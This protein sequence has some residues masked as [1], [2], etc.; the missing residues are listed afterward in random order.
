MQRA[1]DTLITLLTKVCRPVSRRLSVTE[2]GDLLVISLIH[3]S[4]TSKKIRVAAQKM[5]KSGL[6]WND[7]ES[8]F[9]LIVKQRFENTNSR[10]I[11]TEE[12]FKSWMKLSSLN[13]EKFIVLIKKTNNFDEINNFFM[14]NCWNKI[15]I[16]RSIKRSFV[17]ILELVNICRQISCYSVRTLFLLQ[18]FF[19]WSFSEFWRARITLMRFT[20]SDNSS[21]WTLSFPNFLIWRQVL[22]ENF[23]GAFWSQLPFF[24]LNRLS[25]R[26]I[27]SHTTQVCGR[28]Q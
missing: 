6:F 20:L 27:L 10:P 14:N 13:E 25:R 21:R 17:R 1:V 16:H 2:Q 3:S 12:V 19:L 5:S 11:M 15:G 4:Q 26:R 18:G 23:D 8:R 22:L 28:R 7:K 24:T 9:T